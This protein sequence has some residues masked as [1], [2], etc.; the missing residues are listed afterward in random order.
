MTDKTQPAIRAEQLETLSELSATAWPEQGLVV[1]GDPHDRAEVRRG[2][3]L[4]GWIEPSA[5]FA[6]LLVFQAAITTK[7]NGEPHGVP[8]PAG[9]LPPRPEQARDGERQRWLPAGH[10]DRP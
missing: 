10:P 1:T 4:I 9:F 7:D 6:G 8:F 3:D 2:D 5:K